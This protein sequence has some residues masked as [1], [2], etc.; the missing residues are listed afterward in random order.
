M[1]LVCVDEA[2]RFAG[3]VTQAAVTRV[4][5]ETYRRDDLAVRELA[6]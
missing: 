2:G 4:L 5:G 6:E 3:V 1:W